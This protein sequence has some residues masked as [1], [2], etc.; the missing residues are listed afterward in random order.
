MKD[1][2]EH[3]VNSAETAQPAPGNDVRPTQTEPPI[4]QDT[5]EQK[6]ENLPKEDTHVQDE[7]A[8]ETKPNLENSQE[9]QD[10]VPVEA[11]WIYALIMQRI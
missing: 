5:P 4:Q 1:V 10:L 6:V 7:N 2:K 11:D 8:K 3:A 9:P